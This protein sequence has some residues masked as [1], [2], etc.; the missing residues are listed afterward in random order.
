MNAFHAQNIPDPDCA[1]L[2]HAF[3]VYEVIF[4]Q[5]ADKKHAK[6]GSKQLLLHATITPSLQ[7]A[8]ECE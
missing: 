6:Y 8:V 3:Q 1:I 5:F 7:H 4:S 2:M